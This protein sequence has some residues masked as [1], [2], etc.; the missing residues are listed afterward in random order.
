ME[1]FHRAEPE[2]VSAKDLSH[3]WMVSTQNDLQ[4][5]SEDQRSEDK[6]I[7]TSWEMDER[8]D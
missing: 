6:G 3:L 2:V 7:T 4:S 8:E 5:S 1:E